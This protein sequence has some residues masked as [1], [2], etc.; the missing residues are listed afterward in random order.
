[1]STDREKRA[2][3][4]HSTV[5]CTTYAALH[6]EVEGLDPEDYPDINKLSILGDIAPYSREYNRLRAVV[7]KQSHGNPDLRAQYEQ[8]VDQVRQTKESTLQVDQR[9]FDAPVDKIEG[10]IKSASFHGVELSEYPGRVF[11]FSAVGSSMADLVADELGKSNEMTRAQAAGLA[12]TKLRERDAYLS[13]ALA[14]GTRVNL[15]VARGA[16]DNSQ[17]ARA[18][19]EADGVNINRELI[20]QGFGRFRMDIYI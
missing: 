20:D 10:T 8:I 18:V 7:D 9:R 6:P 15:T 3:S 17:H 12:D 13:T 16:A 11:H 1:M 2:H 4:G 19:F 5:G 14:E